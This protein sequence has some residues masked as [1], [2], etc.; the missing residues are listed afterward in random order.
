MHNEISFVM[1]TS[2]WAVIPTLHMLF[3][4]ISYSSNNL[5]NYIQVW[6]AMCRYR[7]AYAKFIG[8]LPSKDQWD[9]YNKDYKIGPPHKKT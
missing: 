6:C 3:F 8:A 9:E 2:M 7:L 1:I 4:S 5:L